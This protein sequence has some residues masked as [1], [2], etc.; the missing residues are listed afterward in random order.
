MIST[1]DVIARILTI[2]RTIVVAEG[3][4]TVREIASEAGLPS[5][6]VH[7]F[8]LAM[9]RQGILGK[10]ERSGLYQLGPAI[11]EI[12]FAALRQLDV[13]RIFLPYLERLRAASGETVGLCIRVGD[14]RAYIEQLESPHELKA[15]VALGQHYPLFSGAPGHALLSLMSDDELDEFFERVEVVPPNS[16]SPQDEAAVRRAID[17]VRK[18]GY[19]IGLGQTMPGVRAVAVPVHTDIDGQ[20][21]A[22]LTVTGPSERFTEERIESLVPVLLDAAGEISRSMS[23]GDRHAAEGTADHAGPASTETTDVS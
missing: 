21:P 6:S 14:T 20:P 13:R 11:L 5:S 18:N 19:G 15:V 9:E 1:E 3:S 16:A 4:L 2:M 10:D 23:I 22:T 7:R 12:G 8:L 17:A